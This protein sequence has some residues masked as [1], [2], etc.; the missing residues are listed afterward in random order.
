[1]QKVWH[2]LGNPEAS[3]APDLEEPLA[4]LPTTTKLLEEHNGELQREGNAT[5]VTTRS[6]LSTRTAVSTSLIPRAVYNNVRKQFQDQQKTYVLAKQLLTS[7]TP[8]TTSIL[9]S[10]LTNV[11][12]FEG[13]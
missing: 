4:L 9:S 8:N 10:S 6:S 13:S 3:E 12:D 2:H 1:M 5:G 7:F 11:Y